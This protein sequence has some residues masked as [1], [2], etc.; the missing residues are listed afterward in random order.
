M[1]RGWAWFI[2]FLCVY[3][4]IKVAT[5]FLRKQPRMFTVMALSAFMWTMLLG[6]YEVGE[7]SERWETLT[8]FLLVYIGGLL[9]LEAKHSAKDGIVLA[10]HIG[11]WL[12][13]LIALPAALKS[14]HGD[15]FALSQRQTELLMGTVIGV[16][17]FWVT[18]LGVRRLCGEFAFRW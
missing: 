16:A 5:T 3:F 13:P 15:L 18:A 6:Y 2:T 12:L 1:S 10:Q 4:S 14:P 9:M 11:V 8:G 17:G 7:T